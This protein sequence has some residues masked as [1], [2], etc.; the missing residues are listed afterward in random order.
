VLGV[1]GQTLYW[2]VQRVEGKDPVALKQPGRAG[3]KSLLNADRLRRFTQVLE[4]G[5]EGLGYETRLWTATRVADL[6]Q[7]DCDIR[8]HPE[9]LGNP[10][11]DRM[12]QPSADEVQVG[13]DR[14]G[15]PRQRDAALAGAKAKPK[16]RGEPS[17][18]PLKTN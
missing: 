16:Q 7:L 6:I 18:S 12:E 15:G 11:A 14:A 17:S 10:A 2:W 8:Y 3:R 1:H 5:A 4:R 9:V 13:T